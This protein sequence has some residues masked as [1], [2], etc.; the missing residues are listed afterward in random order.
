[1]PLTNTSARFGSLTRALHWLTALLIVT[2]IP[3]GAIANRLPYDTAQALAQKAQL[4]SIH[5]TVG[6]AAF[7]VAALR[8]GWALTQT[9]PAGLHPERRLETALAEAVHWMLYIS[10][11]AVPLTGWVHHAAVSGFAPILW[12]LGQD[13]PLVPKSEAV[14]N[15]AAALHWVFT[16]LLVAS[17]ILHIAGAFKHHLVD[18]DATL[19]RMWRGTQAAPRTAAGRH[20]LPAIIALSVYVAGAALA[21]T[22]AGPAETASAGTVA[23]AAGNWQVTEGTLVFS[24]AQMGTDV[25]GSFAAWSADIRFDEAAGTGSVSVSIDTTSLTLGSVTTQ[26]KT[27]EFFN[28]LDFPTATFQA[29]ITPDPA[30]A[31]TFLAD[32]SLTLRGI[33]LPLQLPFT[34]Q[35]ADGKATMTGSTTIDRRDYKIAESYPDTASVGHVVGIRVDLAAQRVP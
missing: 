5:K 25:A 10:L 11:L 1:M 23:P 6:I 33:S 21:F 17:V 18:R 28:T 16:K 27:T 20:V 31:G 2:A 4:F 15:M 32:G 26:A 3:L 22:I 7:L 19:L 30:T 35:I 9:R 13:L 8:I 14:A 34:L 12:P 24:I 29:A